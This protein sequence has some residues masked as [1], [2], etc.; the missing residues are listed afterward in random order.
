M[1]DSDIKPLTL[2]DPFRSPNSARSPP[3]LFGELFIA[4]PRSSRPWNP[5]SKQFQCSNYSQTIRWN[6]VEFEEESVTFDEPFVCWQSLRP[7]TN[8]FCGKNTNEWNVVP[9]FKGTSFF[10]GH[11]PAD[12]SIGNVAK[13]EMSV[14]AVAAERVPFNNSFILLLKKFVWKW[15]GKAD[16]MHLKHL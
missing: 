6:V 12:N 13:A 9:R 11:I 8:F 15:N 1:T 10:D 16:G 5:R 14:S 2:S 3:R 4:R 7:P